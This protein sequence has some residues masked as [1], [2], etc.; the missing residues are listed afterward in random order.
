MAI[1]RSDK[2]RCLEIENQPKQSQQN[3]RFYRLNGKLSNRLLTL[4]IKRHTPASP[5]Y[6]TDQWRFINVLLTYLLTYL[7]TLT[8]I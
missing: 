2:I 4:P 6:L 8:I 5:N 7:L 3:E 1:G